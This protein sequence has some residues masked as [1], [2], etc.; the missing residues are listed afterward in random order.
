[1]KLCVD[2]SF[3]IGEQHLRTGKPCQDYALSGVLESGLYYGIVSDGCSSGGHTDIGARVTSLALKHALEDGPI[4]NLVDRAQ[5]HQ[6]SMRRALQLETK[7]M[8]ATGLVAIANDSQLVDTLILGDGVMVEKSTHG[9][10]YAH[11]YEWSDNTPYYLA[12]AM[13]ERESFLKRQPV[14]THEFWSIS[15]PEDYQHHQTIEES[16]FMATRQGVR[17]LYQPPDGPWNLQSVAVF[18]DGVLQV[19]TVPWQ[20]VVW[21]LMSFKSTNGQFVTRRMNR[22]LTE[23]KKHGRGPL[24]DIAMAVIHLDSST[25]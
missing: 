8:L 9:T 18:S 22:F 21:E 14:L 5:V 24:D 17:W 20:Q 7:D 25:T 12:Y 2:H 1:M 10:L 13:G 6:D 11:K 4:S 23:A 19:A 3:H 15:G 16:A